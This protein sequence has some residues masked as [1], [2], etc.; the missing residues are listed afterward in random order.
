MN[1]IES[2]LIGLLQYLIPGFITAWIFHALTSHP[3]TNQFERV[4]TALIFTVFIQILTLGIEQFSYFVGDWHSFGF[5]TKT[6]DLV[7]STTLAVLFGFVL[8]YLS[9]SDKLHNI[10]RRLEITKARSHESEWYST[11][12]QYEDFAVFHFRDGKRL[13]GQTLE[14]PLD[15]KNGHFTVGNARWLDKANK[16]VK[17]AGV[18][19]V[20]FEAAQI[21]MVEFM[22]GKNDDE[23]QSGP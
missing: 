22:E 12:N 8:V 16:Q 7:M 20:L 18:A 19:A 10:L 5:W 23:E 11:F 21:E 15:H 3:K 13:Y 1:T 6:S 4:V 9:N 14:W 2:D 17:L